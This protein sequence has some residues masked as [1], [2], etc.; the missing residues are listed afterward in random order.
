MPAP[1]DTARRAWVL[2]EDRAGLDT[3]EQTAQTYGLVAGNAH[4]AAELTRR[5]IA[6]VSGGDLQSY[7]DALA[8]LNAVDADLA[9]LQP[10]LSALSDPLRAIM[11]AILAREGLRYHALRQVAAKLDAPFLQSGLAGL[12][13][14]SGRLSGTAY[15]TGAF[16]AGAS[17]DVRRGNYVFDFSSATGRKGQSAAR[18]CLQPRLSRRPG[19]QDMVLNALAVAATRLRPGT[20]QALRI[21]LSLGA[22]IPLPQITLDSD[23]APR[24]AQLM[25]ETRTLF[26]AAEATMD[27]VLARRGAPVQASFNHVGDAVVAGFQASLRKAGVPCDM[28]S[29]GALAAWGTGPRQRVAAHLGAMYNAFPG[30]TTLRPRARHLLPETVSARI[31][32]RCRVTPPAPRRAGP[33]RIY[34]VPNFRPWSEGFW[35][36]TNTCFDTLAVLA[37]MAG[38]VRHSDDLE[39]FLRIKLTAKDIA[40]PRKRPANR[41][42]FP[43]DAAHLLCPADGVHDASRGAHSGYLADADLVVTEGLTAVMFEALEARR[44]VLLILPDPRAVPALPAAPLGRL[45]EPGFRSAVYSA[46]IHD[47][48][49]IG[50][51]RL[52]LAHKDKPL[53]DEEIAPFIWT[54]PDPRRRVIGARPN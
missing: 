5:G 29:H 38:V 27:R 19:W 16:R 37:A 23:F 13:P 1:S 50:V 14:V 8:A 26:A 48:L 46:S 17:R 11:L 4:I 35:G 53:L 51:H 30:M 15:I 6:H 52:S 44:P 3:A 40:N 36:I 28:A 10:Q 18:A 9:Q 34:A 47:D 22:E 49:A 45:A 39:M 42:L 7:E 33:F 32:T 41:G 12:E 31:Q 25:A 21:S 43:E 54:T 20:P 2:I 24:A